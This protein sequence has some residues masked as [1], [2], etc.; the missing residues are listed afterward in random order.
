VFG[1]VPRKGE[2]YEYQGLRFEVK[3]A[4]R[5]KI[6]KL[7]VSRSLSAKALSADSGEE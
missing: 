7:L 3:E 6:H 1:R 2:N 4:D 5:R